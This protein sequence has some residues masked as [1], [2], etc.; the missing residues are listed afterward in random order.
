[1][2]FE[3][4][5]LKDCFLI[6]PQVFEDHRG[7]FLETYH[8]KKF[9]EATGIDVE[10]VQ[11]NQSVSRRGVLRGLHFQRGEFAQAKLVR[12]IYGEVMDVV[13]DLRPESPTFKK[14]HH[15][16]LNDKDHQQLYIPQGFAHGFLT[17]SETSVFSYKCDRFYKPG[18]ESGIIYNDPDLAIAWGMKEEEF[19]LSEKDKILPTLKASFS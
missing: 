9:F 6:T 2:Q 8:K 17:L 3:E 1:M 13:V 11:D 5:P 14:S 7:I 16:I 4:T 19:I 12:V 10:F 18:E 15:L